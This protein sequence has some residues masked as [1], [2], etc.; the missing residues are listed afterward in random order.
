MVRLAALMGMG[1]FA[2]HQARYALGYRG[3]ASQELVSQGHAYLI[4]L[5]PL[6]A[7]VLMLAL[8][9]LIRRVARGGDGPA[10]RF[11]RVWAG[12]TLALAT[13]Y[14]AQELIEGAV[15]SHHPEG[16]AGVAGHG[17]WVALPLALVIGLG[18]ALAMRGAG[19]AHEL[20]EP[21]R[22]WRA[23][24][25]VQPTPVELVTRLLA[26]KRSGAALAHAPRGPPSL[27]A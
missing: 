2:V 9:A 13:V 14:T 19:A 7:G 12:A 20:A 4:A 3:E 15:A 17:G 24:V 18:I 26:P 22:P 5:G 8:A 21:L 6:L 1:T 25:P 27:S 10:P 11:R 16:V 23:P